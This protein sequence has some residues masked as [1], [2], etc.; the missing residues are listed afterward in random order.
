MKTH[1]LVVGAHE[2][3]KLHYGSSLP[4][5]E[6]RNNAH[7]FSSYL[8]DFAQVKL[9]DDSLLLGKQAVWQDFQFRLD[10]FAKQFN[11]SEEEE[12]LIVYM[13]GHGF[14]YEGENKE[15]KTF[16]CFYD[17]MVAEQEL[18]NLFK[19]FRANSR[20]W[21]IIDSCYAGG[22]PELDKATLYQKWINQDSKFYDE[23]SAY[24]FNKWNL[25]DSSRKFDAS[26]LFYGASTELEKSFEKGRFGTTK[27]TF[28]IIEVM[29]EIGR[30]NEN[31]NYH[32]LFEKVADD[33][34]QS[35]PMMTDLGTDQSF[36]L[37]NKPLSI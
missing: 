36:F 22:F 32:Q 12:L 4:T 27:F 25:A 31:L 26:I 15:I 28:R 20:I 13:T 37:N 7:I 14:N 29:D 8:K 3:N 9:W 34:Y 17:Q 1:V 24:Y 11:D 2:L 5:S 19:K 16:F 18:R 6:V 23:I 33:N 35:K 30:M 21:W 10:Q